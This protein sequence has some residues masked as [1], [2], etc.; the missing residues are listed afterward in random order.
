MRKL[1]DEYYNKRNRITLKELEKNIFLWICEMGRNYTREP[2]EKMI[3]I[4]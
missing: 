3:T 1:Y 4:E 2:L